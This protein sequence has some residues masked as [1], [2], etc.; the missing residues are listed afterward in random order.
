MGNGRGCGRK[1]RHIGIEI[2]DIYFVR[3]FEYFEFFAG[4]FPEYPDSQSGPGKRMSGDK[5]F[6]YAERD[7]YPA[8][9]ILEERAQRLY[10]LELHLLWQA[11][12]IV[13]RF[14]RSG[15]A[16]DRAALYYVGIDRALCKPFCVFYLFGLCV[17]DFYEC[18]SYGFPFAFRVRYAGK[19]LEKE[20]GSIYSC[21]VQ[22]HVFV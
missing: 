4:Y 17:E 8:H 18:F 9:L 2:V 14:Y 22:S 3:L 15:R 11:S 13:V 21:Y 10:H 12:Y 6:L 1:F 20:S 5:F 19:S 16:F 7:A